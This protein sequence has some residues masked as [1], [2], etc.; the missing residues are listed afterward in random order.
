MIKEKNILY[1]SAIVLAI[2]FSIE[3]LSFLAW[4]LVIPF[5][6]VNLKSN[7]RFKDGYKLGIKYFLLFY[8]TA[9]MWLIELYPLDWLGIEDKFSIPLILGSW[10]VISLVEAALMA[11]IIPIFQKIKGKNLLINVVSLSLVWIIFEWI[12]SLSDFGMPWARLAITQAFNPSLIQ[13]ASLFGSLFISLIILIVNGLIACYFVS[14]NKAKKKYLILCLAIFISNLSF[15]VYNLNKENIERNVKVLL[16]Q[17]NIASN[18]K[19]TSGSAE[20]QVD[21]YIK[22]TEESIEALGE[23]PQIIVW[24]ETAVTTNMEKSPKIKAKLESLSEKYS[25]YVITGS[26]SRKMVDGENLKYNSLYTFSPDKV[27]QEPYSKRHLVPFGEFLPF[28]KIV[29][30]IFKNVDFD[31]IVDTIIPGEDAKIQNTKYG[32]LGGIICFESI[33]PEVVR[34]STISGSELI[35]L[36]TNDSWFKD[37]VALYQHQRHAILRAVENDRYVVRAA[38]TG[39]SSVITNKGEILE[40]TGIL[41]EDIIL[42]SVKMIDNRTLYSYVGEIIVLFSFIWCIYFYIKRS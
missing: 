10:V 28:E 39:I 27:V 36:I 8:M 4:F 30:P 6:V 24:P 40:S 7:M 1:I 11:F 18:V 37:S 16:I 14:S 3:K 34:D 32:N 22:M 12:Q 31:S 21:K 26:I 13:S 17:G 2:S 19:W 38:N 9:F 5:F 29:K 42:Q 41:E 23:I 20:E 15:G 33:F 25:A 35:V